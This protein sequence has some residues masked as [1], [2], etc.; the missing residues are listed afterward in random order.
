MDPKRIVA[1]VVGASVMVL[2]FSAILVPIIGDATDHTTTLKNVTNTT[3]RVYEIGNDVPVT[4]TYADGVYSINGVS[5]TPFNANY[6][7]ITSDGMVLRISGGAYTLFADGASA[8]MAS[9]NL[10]ANNGSITGTYYTTTEPDTEKTADWAY[11]YLFY[12]D[13][14]GKYVMTGAPNAPA[15]VY[16]L[17]DTEVYC[18][19]Y[20]T[21]LGGGTT[22][23]FE[24]KG[25]I[26]DGFTFSYGTTTLT[27][28]TVNAVE[29]DGYEETVY[30]VTNFQIPINDELTV[31]ISRY[32]APAEIEVTATSDP[33][34]DALLSAIP[35]IAMIGI[36]LAV[37]GVAIVGRNDY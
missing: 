6:S 37:V 36:V 29:L 24:F 13:S 35:I 25:S 16:L 10:T 11:T 27:D 19:G 1:L 31:T 7:T 4:F 33:A 14:N 34:V 18:T 17:G 21:S 5:Y 30:A 20:N 28:V 15:T 3:D 32:V 22:R 8:A 9:F 23:W 2:M 12:Q 26:N